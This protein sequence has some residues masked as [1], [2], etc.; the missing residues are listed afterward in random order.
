MIAIAE[1]IVLESRPSGTVKVLEGKGKD[2]REYTRFVTTDTTMFEQGEYVL[3]QA[4]FVSTAKGRFE[5]EVQ[6]APAP[7]GG[8]AAI[9]TAARRQS[10]EAVKANGEKVT[11]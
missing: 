4:D 3:V 6:L 2:G 10:R 1:G 9:M 11:A 7:D 8:L 5:R